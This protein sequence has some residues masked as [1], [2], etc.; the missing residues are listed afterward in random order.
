[1]DIRSF[2]QVS[3]HL[4]SDIAVL[5]RGETGIGKSHI[6]H[7]IGVY[8]QLPVI[9][10]R[11]SQ[12]TEGDIIGLPSLQDN[13]TKFLPVDWIKQAS[14]HPVLL[15]LDELNRASL[16]VQQA[17]FQLVLDREINGVKLH[18][19]TRVFTAINSGVHYQ[20]N[21]MDPA[22]L[23]RF[24][25]IDLEPTVQDW[26]NWAEKTPEM[27]AMMVSFI[28]DNPHF[29]Q[30]S[31]NERH[32]NNKIFPTP[33]SWHRFSRSLQHLN[34]SLEKYKG[35]S[36]PDHVYHLGTGFVGMESTLALCDYIERFQIQIRVE[37]ILD[38]WLQDK[39]RL[40]NLSN[41]VVVDLIEKLVKNAT[42]KLTWSSQQ[43]K[44]T[45]DFIRCYS[46]E[47]QVS[48]FNKIMDCGNLNTVMVVHKHMGK[49]VVDL[50]NNSSLLFRSA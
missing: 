16:E 17:V 19:K 21:Q 46:S 2:L 9:D 15:F 49:E 42:H 39:E 31:S 25:T 5:V 24:W 11:L 48:F 27:D 4:P 34:C 28:Q 6:I 36:I 41:E 45:C 38:N 10:R 23:R 13:T 37:N 18:P 30:F 12:M 29:L 8:L 33:A 7:Q 20:V 35:G 50:V 32:G 47:L 14:Q 43:A 44:N 26:I 22:L 1:M 3:P 40:S